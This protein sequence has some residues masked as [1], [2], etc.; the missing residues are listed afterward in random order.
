MRRE[1]REWPLHDGFLLFIAPALL[2]EL[3]VQS[4]HA[5]LLFALASD[6]LLAESGRRRVRAG[7]DLVGREVLACG[8]VGCFERV[9]RIFEVRECGPAAR[10]Q[11]VRPVGNA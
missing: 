11:R 8:H 4:K 3:L 6:L 1:V 2:V 5:L 9:E 7:G 10:L